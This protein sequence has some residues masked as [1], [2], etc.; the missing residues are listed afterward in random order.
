MSMGET[1]ILPEMSASFCSSL[2]CD[3]ICT[4][5]VEVFYGTQYDLYDRLKRT[6]I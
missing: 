3:Q 4:L 6:R 2:P 5:L 1:V